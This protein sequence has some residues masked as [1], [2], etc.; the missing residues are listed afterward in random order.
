MN[1]YVWHA[2]LYW[3]WDFLPL[4]HNS[5]S[6]KLSRP[7]TEPWRPS[8]G[9]QIWAP[10]SLSAPNPHTPTAATAAVLSIIKKMERT[11]VVK[12]RGKRSL[13][14][15]R[16]RNQETSRI[17]QAQDTHVANATTSS[18]AGR[19][20]S[21]T[22]GENTARWMSRYSWSESQVYFTIKSVQSLNLC[23]D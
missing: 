7:S 8:K 6:V 11:T 3:I 18:A 19:P 16:S 5:A 13:H 17:L 1:R 4:N 22:W 14:L 2:T 15:Y 12:T 20:S 10:T 23:S 9:H 21:P